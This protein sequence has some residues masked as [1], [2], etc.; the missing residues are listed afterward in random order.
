M[1]DD[2]EDEAD[3]YSLDL[4]E[5]EAAAEKR[6]GG[7]SAFS[8][9]PKITGPMDLFAPK[10]PAVEKPASDASTTKGDTQ[11]GMKQAPG[12][13]NV[14]VDHRPRASSPLKAMVVPSPE[15]NKTSSPSG[16]QPSE[17]A[18]PAFAAAKPAAT[19]N[20]FAPPSEPKEGSS[21]GKQTFNFGL[22]LGKPSAPAAE[23]TPSFNFGTPAKTADA[24]ASTTPAGPAPSTGFNFRAPEKTQTSAPSAFSF[25]ASSSSTGPPV[26]SGDEVVGKLL[27]WIT[28]FLLRSC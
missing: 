19:S 18:S 12:F 23:S 4:A 28:E 2:D 16:S 22:G 24:Q 21:S 25:G 5:L 15:S 3:G 26:S 11:S 9:A 7:S 13:L 20:F 10:P 27:I 6:Q 1:D 14:K 17:S 8:S